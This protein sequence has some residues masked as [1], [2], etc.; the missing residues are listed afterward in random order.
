[1]C[2][3]WCIVLDNVELVEILTQSMSIFNQYSFVFS[4]VVFGTVLLF[5]L[6]RWQSGPIWLR[7]GVMLLF[8]VVAVGINSL[9]RYPDSNVETVQD[10]E[11]LLTNG[12]PTFLVFY[13]NY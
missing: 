1:M 2:L 7:G 13:S 3:Y 6:M 8:V 5:A 9:L 4:A 12:N 11:T 10:A